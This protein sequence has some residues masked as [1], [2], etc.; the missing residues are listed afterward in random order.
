[1]RGTGVRR[2]LATSSG[3]SDPRFLAW[4]RNGYG[5]LVSASGALSF[6]P[7]FDG[8]FEFTS[9]PLEP[10]ANLLLARA[11]D[12][13]SGFESPESDPVSVEVPATLFPDLSV[14]ATEIGSYPAVPLVGQ[15]AALR[16]RVRNLGSVPAHN[17]GAHVILWN[18]DGDIGLD[19][20]LTLAELPGGQSTQLSLAW[21]PPAAGNYAL[22]LR[23]DEEQA[24]TEGREDNNTASATVPVVTT[25]GL[26][27]SVDSD[28]PAY[29]ARTD[30]LVSVGILNGSAA[31]E[32]TARLRVVDA[33]GTEVA[34]VDQRSVSLPYGQQFAYTARW[35]TGSTYAGAYAFDLQ[36]VDGA[37]APAGYASHAFTIQ[38]DVHV[39][40]RLQ[41]AA[42]SV[43]LGASASFHGRIDNLGV[44]APQ[45]G[46]TARLAILPEGGSSPVSESQPESLPLLLPSASWERD[47]VWP[48]AAPAGRYR[49]ELRV[50]QAGSSLAVG[51]A[52]FEVLGPA[53][54][55]E[56][57]VVAVP[58]HVM[59]GSSF[60]A[61]I[62]V[63]NRGALPLV[64]YPLVVDVLSGSQATV[65]A[66]QSLA[67]DLAPGQ[68]FADVLTFASTALAPGPYALALRG[69]SPAAILARSF[70]RVH[71]PI[72]PPSIDA[73]PDG[74]T[75]DTPHP[76]LVV[77]NAV[78]AEGA[79][80][81]Y[82]FQIYPD[83]TLQLPL[84]G[85]TGVPESP[86][87]TS[88]R[89]ATRL[90]EDGVYYWRA[91]AGDGFSQSA[92]SSLAW[93]R[94]DAENR[95]PAAPV[96]DTP[97]AGS[98]VSTRQPSL[99]VHNAVDLDYD[100]LTYDYR[101]A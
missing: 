34:L 62:T 3:G 74:S 79:T 38:P 35:N 87:R 91:R 92:W 45:S 80:L 78:S 27:A 71:G 88:W 63:T 61:R 33:Q 50:M 41:A 101:L 21:T 56:G 70:L 1:E 86:L 36:L 44:N 54:T 73:P 68:A 23:V 52:P 77:N 28:R 4:T 40:A 8:A 24:I 14:L 37:G 20:R 15:A 67:V 17:V 18:P 11:R 43:M 46:L 89:V 69:G 7:G 96:P 99:V 81:T 84:P 94:V 65:V 60:E 48:G 30:A 98:R 100:A 49:A 64:A 85:A 66:S 6:L 72:A 57:T 97:A 82:E 5:A 31:I 42:A 22:D 13:R 51:G 2:T 9:V 76:L 32:G 59:Q 53:T 25:S 75:V 58:N 19:T 93:F 29:P 12:P 26:V 95:P 55:V 47:F 83:A 10:G 39:A 16:V 90:P